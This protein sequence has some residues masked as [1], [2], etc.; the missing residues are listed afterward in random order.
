MIPPLHLRPRR[1][2]TILG[3]GLLGPLALAPAAIGAEAPAPAE[4]VLTGGR[5][6]TLDPAR[7]EASALAARDGRIVALGS[8]A[9]IA[10]LVGP[11]TRRIDLAGRLAVPG[12]VDAHAHFEGLGKASRILKLAPYRTWNEIVAAVAA[13][14]RQAAPGEWILGRGWH[15]E[16]WAAPPSPEV[17]GFPVHASLS[18]A[19]PDHPVVLVHASGHASLVNARAMEIAGISRATADPP[20]GQILRDSRGEPT[21]VLRESAE[22]L[23]DAAYE[24]SLARRP[25]EQVEAD[26]RRDLRAG[27]RDALSKGVTTLHDAGI[28]LADLELVRSEA[29]GGGLGI[30]LYGM[31]RDTPERLLAADLATLR[32]VDPAGH[33]TLRTLKIVADGALGSRG[34]WLLAPYSDLPGHTGLAVTEPAVVRELAEHAHA[35]GWQVAV[36]AIGD[37]AN[38]ET[39][40]VYESVLR[41]HPEARDLRWRIEHAQHLDPAEVPRFAKLGVIASMQG[42]H[43][44]SDG[45]WVP[46]RIGERRARDGA[47]V[48]RKLLDAG[49]TIANGTDA[50][51][52]DVDPLANFYASVSRKLP[53]GSRF[54]PDQR[55]TRLEALESYT[56]AGA[57]AGFEEGVKG[58][59]TAG[60]L[61]DVVVLSKDVLAIP[62]DEIPSARVDLTIV[63][64]NVLYD[65]QR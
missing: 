40:D 48:W 27:A 1:F 50:P 13:A 22:D 36:H 57:Y 43:C 39:L 62:E 35:A 46:V 59:L 44:T 20:G 65:A 32:R 24:A 54:Y 58:T 29:A 30:R 37:R 51:V 61:A 10:R 16:K 12:F 33:F 38:R 47:Y 64:G 6:V 8:D 63:G 42:I 41:G 3:L 5:I 53:D 19:V 7:P 25:P 18:A 14:A 52:E 2:R 55:M 23:V 56:K 21:G 34:A 4:L 26:R 11:A 15:Q 9:E 45:P 28:L 60:K 49:A 31:L 17:E